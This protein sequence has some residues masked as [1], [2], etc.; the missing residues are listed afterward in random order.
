MRRAVLPVALIVASVLVAWGLA[1][2]RTPPAP[3]AEADLRPWV[4]TIRVDPRPL[5]LSVATQGEVLPRM[6]ID[7]V[8]EVSGRVV[9]MAPGL[10]AGGFFQEGEVLVR[11]DPRDYRAAVARAEAQVAQ[12]RQGVLTEE[13]EAELARSELEV[14]GEPNPSPLARREPQLAVARAQFTA[15]KADLAQ[16]RLDLERTEVRA[17]FA[18]RVR[19][20][21]VGVGQF[22]S[23]GSVIAR[24]YAVDSAEVRLPLSA[25][26][27]AYLDLPLAYSQQSDPRPAPGVRLSAEIAGQAWSWQGEI[28]R[29]E[30]ALERGTRMVMAVARVLDPYE[31]ERPAEERGMPLAVGLFVQAEVQ[32]RRI[33]NVVSLPAAAYRPDRG[34][35]VVDDEDRL[36][37]RPV[38]VLRREKDEVLVSGGLEPGERVAITPLDA[39]VDGMS[40]RTSDARRAPADESPSASERS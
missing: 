35:L 25:D 28:V 38:T 23:A 2:S 13:E 15:A 31:Q 29:T 34:V 3:D 18:G 8:A 11:I 40:V 9:S 4:E 32:G 10:D 12:A 16:A 6:E 17:P 30:A 33:E 22:L 37:M 5:D 19:D 14:L 36:R 39:P 1:A 20:R 27:L 24:A 21:M 7:L 26:D